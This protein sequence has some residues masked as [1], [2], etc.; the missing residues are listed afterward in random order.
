MSTFD[1]LLFGSAVC[2][3]VMVCGSMWL[4]YKGIITLQAQSSAGQTVFEV[5][6]FLK[7]ATTVPSL[8]LFAFGA[9]FVYLA[10]TFGK[11]I[12][13][14][15]TKFVE[16]KKNFDELKKQSDASRF[17]IEA[18]LSGTD[19]THTE[20][21]VCMGDPARM[22]D[23]VH[24]Q[25]GPHLETYRVELIAPGFRPEHRTL[26]RT[27]NNFHPSPKK[28][29]VKNGLADLGNIE[30]Q[31]VATKPQ[32]ADIKV[33]AGSEQKIIAPTGKSIYTGAQ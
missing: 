33:H 23:T 24:Y 7:L 10:L 26:L 3:L 25:I 32:E 15:Q 27:E 18:T 9:L 4:M 30:M 31:R 5:S 16:L 13:E 28:H 19:D 21:T 12:D 8:A 6:K 17:W 2:G 29:L 1:L 20:M 14:M 11:P 22:L